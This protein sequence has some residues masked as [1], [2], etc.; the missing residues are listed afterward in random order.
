MNWRRRS[1][2]S[3]IPLLV[4]AGSALGPAT[5]ARASTSAL[6]QGAI[7]DQT[8][9]TPTGLQSL[10]GNPTETTPTLG[11]DYL[12]ANGGWAGMDGA[13]GSLGYLA[14]WGGNADQLVLGVPIIPKSLDLPVGSLQNG[15]SGLYDKYFTQLAQTLQG[16]GLGNAWLRLGWEFDN[17]G[18]PWKAATTTAEG[19]YA[20]YFR[21]IVTT[22]RAVPGTNFKFVW[23]PDAYAFAGQNDPVHP[24]YDP[25]PAWPGAAYVDYIGLDLYDEAPGPGYTPAT[26]WS[27]IQPEL[28]AAEQFA[29]TNGGEPLA[30]PEWGVAVPVAGQYGMGDD[31]LY[32]N[33]MY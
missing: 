19:Y 33:N 25:S 13:N 7:P 28:A 14:P 24:G 10:F 32:V 20:S 22:M 8:N 16:L 15:A 6:I 9:D 27:W 4:V 2:A 23:N 30:F 18:Y 21:N 26:L 12:P 11:T 31:P 5:A 17:N 29:S 1:V 3:L